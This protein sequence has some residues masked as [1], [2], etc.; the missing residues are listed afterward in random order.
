[1]LKNCKFSVI[2]IKWQNPLLVVGLY[3][4]TSRSEILHSYR[5]VIH[6][7]WR[8]AH[9]RL[10]LVAND[11]QKKN[12][13][14]VVVHEVFAGPHGNATRIRNLFVPHTSATLGPEI[15]VNNNNDG[16]VIDKL[17]DLTKVFC[18][19][20]NAFGFWRDLFCSLTTLGTIIP[21]F[22]KVCQFINGV[23]LF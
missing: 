14:C 23:P 18:R 5:D 4:L 2:I 7:G 10:L 15:I 20:K 3:T 22:H 12:S 8:A 9:F 17:H 1:M 13:L 19:N 6:Y 21:F 11:Q 16:D